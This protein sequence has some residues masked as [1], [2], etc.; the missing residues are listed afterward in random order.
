MKT[1]RGKKPKPR[2]PTARAPP[3]KRPPDRGRGD[4]EGDALEML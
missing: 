1:E 2:N 3:L 4:I